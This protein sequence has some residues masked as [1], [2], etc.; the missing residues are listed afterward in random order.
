[1]TEASRPQRRKR[2]KRRVSAGEAAPAPPEG[3]P[4]AD[5]AWEGKA[6][7]L[8]GGAG[9]C[10]ALLTVAA[11]TVSAG[12][13]RAGSRD[14]GGDERSLL[15]DIATLGDRQ[16][17]GAI[18]RAAGVALLAGLALYLFRV[19]RARNPAHGKYVPAVGLVAFALL[20]ATT[21]VSYAEVRDVAREFVASGPRT[22]ARAE[23]LLDAAREDGLLRATNIL[24]LLGALL[25]GVW[26][27]LVS[28]EAM[29]VGIL[30]TFLGVFGI[31][32]GLT[33]AAGI[34]ELGASLFL[35]WLVS[36]S[37]LALGWWPGG[38]PAAWDAGRAV[39]TQARGRAGP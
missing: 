13:T 3:A 39:P 23:V 11:V 34:T 31:V 29:R 18:M 28:Y 21:L 1:M 5:I 37:L 22:A 35:G 33:S 17:A 25:F 38:R 15:L 19:I 10:T 9:L 24:S 14:S 26:V 7:R 36:V 6:G 30:T 32:A 20:T 8:A 4:A 2:R 12:G 27:S 16:L